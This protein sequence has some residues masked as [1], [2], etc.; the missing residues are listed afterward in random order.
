V[1]QGERIE[2]LCAWELRLAERGL[3]STLCF[4]RA[5]EA[6]RDAWTEVEAMMERV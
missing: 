3:C 2:P 1:K 4:K 6:K 5:D